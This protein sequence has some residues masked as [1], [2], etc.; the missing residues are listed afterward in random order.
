MRT[1]AYRFPTMCSAAAI[2]ATAAIGA[3]GPA[4][5]ACGVSSGVQSGVHTGVGTGVKSGVTGS[6]HGTSASSCPSRTNATIT[7]NSAMPGGGVAGAH[8]LTH[9]NLAQTHHNLQTT[10]LQTPT[11]TTSKTANKA[12][13]PKT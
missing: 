2:I 4:F 1:K 10:N 8:I 5:A 9:N 13:K 7:A 3:S 11:R 6:T 12:N